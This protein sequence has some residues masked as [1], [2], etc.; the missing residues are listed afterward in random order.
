MGKGYDARVRVRQ[1][2]ADRLAKRLEETRARIQETKDV[3][4]QLLDKAVQQVLERQR[5]SPQP[6]DEPQKAPGDPGNRRPEPGQ[7]PR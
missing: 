1:Y 5:V 4:E 3:R 2:E 7:R 6:G